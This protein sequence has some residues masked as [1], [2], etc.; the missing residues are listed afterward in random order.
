MRV[1]PEIEMPAR[2]PMRPRTNTISE[3]LRRKARRE[4]SRRRRAS[5]RCRNLSCDDYDMAPR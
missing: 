1:E 4:L 2:E 5:T 3:E